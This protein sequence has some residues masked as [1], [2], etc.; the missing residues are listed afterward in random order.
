MTE[1]DVAAVAAIEAGV[2]LVPWSAQSFRD[3]LGAGYLCDVLEHAGEVVGYRILSEVL[4]EAHLLNIAVAPSMQR[5]GLAWAM[6]GDL[7]ERCRAHGMSILYLE[8]RASNQPAIALYER[9]GF[10][11]SGVRRNYYRTRDGREDALLMVK[12]LTAGK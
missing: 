10:A 12:R 7:F 1:Q 5:R 2:H 6:L 9:R 3:C 4:D 8:V 11:R